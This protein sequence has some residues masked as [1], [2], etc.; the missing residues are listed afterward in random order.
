MHGFF[1]SRE[2]LSRELADE[3]FVRILYN[4]F[5][6]REYD[7]NGLADWTQRLADGMSRDECIAG[8]ADSPEFRS[9]MARYGI[10]E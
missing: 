7:E 6:D 10:R 4:T 9:I 2:F 3:E 8:F 1:H 5:L